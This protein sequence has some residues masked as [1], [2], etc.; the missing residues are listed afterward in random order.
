MKRAAGLVGWLVVGVVV[1]ADPVGAE[2][3]A[4]EIDKFP[5]DLDGREVEEMPYGLHLGGLESPV[6]PQ[7]G[8]LEDVVGLLPALQ[9]RASAKHAASE[10]EHAVRSMAD[11]ELPGPRVTRADRID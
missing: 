1:A 5:A 2:V 7:H 6:E 9:A 3:L 11:E 10:D 4:A 8:V